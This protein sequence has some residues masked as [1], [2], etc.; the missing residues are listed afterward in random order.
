[1]N[2]SNPSWPDYRVKPR[3][4]I[5]HRVNLSSNELLHPEAAGLVGQLVRGFDTRVLLRYPVQDL[6]ARSAA[7]M[8]DR[9]SEEILLAPGSDSVI[10]L[11]LTATHQ[12]FCGRLI[13]QEP[14]Y[15]AWTTATGAERWAIT[16]VPNPDST[17]QGW[18]DAVIAA[19]SVAVPSVVAVSWPNGPTGDAPEPM[20]LAVLRDVCRERGHLLVL[21]GCYSAF[22]GGPKQ[23]AAL[24]GADCLVLL[25]WSKMFGLAGGR[26]AVAIGDPDLVH[27]LRAFRQ[28][29]HVNALML[30]A[31][32]RTPLLYDRFER[33][34][35]DVV[36]QR[37]A[38]REWLTALGFHVPESGG[39]FLRVPLRTSGDAAELAAMLDGAGFR[40]RNM[41]GLN[42]QEHAVRFTVACGPE[43][44]RF[45]S[46]L[47]GAL[48]KVRY[49]WHAPLACPADKLTSG[50]DRAQ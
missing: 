41:A 49:R 11:L 30:Y 17:A 29:D 44:H 7:E 19:A 24:G 4:T 36:D 5:D 34:W 35:A 20:S 21:D 25:S 37:E 40:V 10:R 18:L 27:Y 26:L 8:F 22:S 42:G 13:L 45:R 39:N 33:V 23:L 3:R 32:V 28:E 9:A 12:A 46:A 16:R 6:P 48:G 50:I 14:N 31:L 1:M 47:A 2:R 38:N 43:G 15:D